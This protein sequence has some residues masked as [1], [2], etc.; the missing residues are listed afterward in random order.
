MLRRKGRAGCKSA[1]C[2]FTRE[3]QCSVFKAISAFGTPPSA[4][5]NGNAPFFRAVSAIL[6]GYAPFFRPFL[7]RFKPVFTPNWVDNHRCEVGGHAP[8]Y[9]TNKNLEIEKIRAL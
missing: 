6:N 8:L 7:G 2:N 3:R 5:V 1:H 4:W 9:P